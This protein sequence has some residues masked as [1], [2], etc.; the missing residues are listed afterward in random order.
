VTDDTNNLG[1]YTEQ[2]C[3]IHVDWCGSRKCFIY[4]NSSM[5]RCTFRF[6]E[7]PLLWYQNNS[8]DVIGN[9]TTVL[10]HLNLILHL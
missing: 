3:P 7:L 2:Y 5:T 4:F 6:P 1:E 8:W 9:S 10:L